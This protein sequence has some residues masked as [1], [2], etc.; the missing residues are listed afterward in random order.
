MFCLGSLSSFT[1]GKV[2][3]EPKWLRNDVVVFV[4][5]C[6]GGRGESVVVVVVVVVRTDDLTNLFVDKRQ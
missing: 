4:V 3:L 2:K 5:V 6:V 1:V